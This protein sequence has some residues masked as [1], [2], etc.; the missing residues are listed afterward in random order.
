[1]K[2]N[3]LNP[4]EQNF[5]Q[6]IINHHK[7]FIIPGILILYFSSAILMF[8]GIV[9][10]YYTILEIYH[11]I[12]NPKIVDHAVKIS[13]NFL[14]IIEVYILALAFYTFAVS[15]YKLFIGNSIPGKLEWI[16]V[17][18]INDLKSHLSKMAVLFL[19]MMIIQKITEWKDPIGTLYLG[20]VVTLTSLVLIL[21]SKHLE[22]IKKH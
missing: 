13:A 12:N 19:C 6:K 1:M 2:L 14:S 7:W 10:L 5:I 16:I 15:V 20:V 3:D 8:V 4:K 22:D 21:F 18:N 11:N 9:K 17:D